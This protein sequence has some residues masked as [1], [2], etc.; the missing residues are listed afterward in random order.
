MQA[1]PVFRKTMIV[2]MLVALFFAAHPTL[3]G[4]KGG[5]QARSPKLFSTEATLA[6]TLTAPWKEFA[7]NKNAKTNYPATLEYVDEAGAKHSLSLTVTTRG[8]N[9]LKVCKFPPIKLIFEKE[10][11]KETPFHGNKS[12]KLVTRCDSDERSEQY[13]VKEILAY[14]IYNLVTERSFKARPLAITYVDRADHSSDGPHFAFLLEDDSDVAKRN[15][16]GKL[17]VTTL[18]LAQLEPL[19]ASRM[20]LFEYLI[21]N[22]D[23]AVLTG[24]PGKPCCHNAVLL[25]ENKPSKVF[26][27]PYDF[28]SSGLVDTN[29]STPSPVLKIRSNRDRVFR[30]FCAKNETLAAARR[31]FLRLEPQILGLARTESHLTTASREA[32]NDYLS[33]GFEVLRDDGKF[34]RDVTEKCR[35]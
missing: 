2:V 30:G 27:A 34:A 8:H 19:E 15:D 11:V 17:D 13:V 3:A 18:D 14:R 24:S 29:Y 4:A 22:T 20:S 9:R 10:A 12:L 31:E 33:K 26:A 7:R 1:I 21:G 5:D 16:L 28:D 23:F 25:G 35:K 32:V 6:L